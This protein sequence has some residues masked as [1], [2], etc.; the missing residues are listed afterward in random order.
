[1]GRWSQLV[2]NDFLACLNLPPSLRWLEMG[3]GTG[4]LTA[5]IA[6]KCR[7]ARLIGIDPSEGF[8]AKARTRLETKATFHVADASGIPLQDSEVDVVV[9]GL[10][11]NFV[12]NLVLGIQPDGSIP[13]VARAWAI[14][15][16]APE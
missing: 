8:L 4:A 6:E 10:L 14:Q 12:P 11:L 7:P 2:A 9:S 16:R 1:V 13:L 15:G 5:A 3:C